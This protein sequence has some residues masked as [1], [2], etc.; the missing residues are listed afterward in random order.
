MEFE[1]WLRRIGTAAAEKP[2][3][4]GNEVQPP[5]VEHPDKW[6][7]VYRFASPETLEAW[8]ASPERMELIAEGASLIKHPATMQRL[9]TRTSDDPV[10]AVSSF[11]LR[12]GHEARFTRDFEEIRAA[13]EA[14]DGF[15]WAQL[16][17]PVG[18]VQKEMVVSFS[19][20]NRELLDRWFRSPERL[21]LLGRLDKHLD[22]ERQVNVVGGY[23]G[24]F[25]LDEKRIPTWRQA[26]VVLMALYP[27]ALTINTLLGALLPTD[28][29]QP[30]LILIGNVLSVMILTWIVMPR[31]T[32]ALD[33]WLRK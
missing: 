20:S 4:L 28:T 2:G 9:A 1:R 11:T 13:M 8:L 16:L 23:G 15:V 18:E 30:L 21:E 19:F 6:V 26:A 24:W 22:G 29:P 32:S 27:T 31:L 17:P 5:G 7:S 33:G 10:T 3:Y 14:F 25:H 12:P